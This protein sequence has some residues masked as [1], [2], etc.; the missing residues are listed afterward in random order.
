M[1]RL[2]CFLTGDAFINTPEKEGSNFFKFITYTVIFILTVLRKE[3]NNISY[4][5]IHCIPITISYILCTITILQ[6]QADYLQYFFLLSGFGF[7]FCL[8]LPAS[9]WST[10]NSL[11]KLD[12]L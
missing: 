6:L 8:F 11:L 5:R 12:K 10:G 2:I 4:I 3:E 1:V 7:S 9:T